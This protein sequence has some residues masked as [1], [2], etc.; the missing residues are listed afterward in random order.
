ML[1]N[2][3]TGFV[4][5]G[6]PSNLCRWQI[7]LFCSEG[8]DLSRRGWGQE[9]LRIGSLPTNG[10]GI[11]SICEWMFVPCHIFHNRGRVLVPLDTCVCGGWHDLLLIELGLELLFCCSLE[12]YSTCELAM[13]EPVLIV[14]S[15]FCF[16][17]I[18]RACWA[19]SLW[20]FV[21]WH[22]STHLFW[23]RVLCLGCWPPFL[24]VSLRLCF[25][26]VQCGLVSSWAWLL[27]S[28]V[29]VRWVGFC[30][31]IVEFSATIALWLSI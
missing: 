10:Q 27:C 17:M 21:W 7:W 31:A 1:P 26:F 20:S 4:R 16:S 24:L 11:R 19:S 18:C 12:F 30:I 29:R 14:Y 5:S 2:G 15:L 23:V 22:S 25:L 6:F 28:I 3:T 13:A 9:I 8:S